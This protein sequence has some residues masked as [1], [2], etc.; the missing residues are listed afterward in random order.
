MYIRI[1]KNIEEDAPLD[2]YCKNG[3]LKHK[4]VFKKRLNKKKGYTARKIKITIFGERT[5]I[6]EN[7]LNN[8]SDH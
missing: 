7:G 6:Y 5:E 4:V 3:Q 2:G 8:Y 1:L